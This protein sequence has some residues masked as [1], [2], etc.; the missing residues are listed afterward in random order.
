M[1]KILNQFF[2]KKL[3]DKCT[4]VRNAHEYNTRSKNKFYLEKLNGNYNQNNTKYKGLK[5]YNELPEYIKDSK[6]L[7]KLKR[8]CRQYIK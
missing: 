5:Q 6:N 1:Y 3:L 2:P 8:E 7:N 4:F